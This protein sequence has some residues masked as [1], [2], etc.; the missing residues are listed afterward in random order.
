MRTTILNNKIHGRRSAFPFSEHLT[1]TTNEQEKHFYFSRQPR[2][3][4]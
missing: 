1:R 3:C 4:G 2:V